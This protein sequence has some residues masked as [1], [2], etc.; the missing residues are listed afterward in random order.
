[1]KSFLLRTLGLTF[2]CGALIGSLEGWGV[3]SL[4]GLNF[5]DPAAEIFAVQWRY[6][7]L[8]LA[9]LPVALPMAALLRLPRKTAI[10]L[11]AWSTLGLAWIIGN[12]WIQTV[13]LRGTPWNAPMS[14]SLLVL[15]SV[16]VFILHRF[17]CKWA[18][19]RPR[20]FATTLLLGVVLLPL[21]AQ[22]KF[23]RLLKPSEIPAN[24]AGLPDITIIV[25]DTLRA[26]HLG[27]YGY[28]RSDGEQTSPAIDQLAAQGVVFEN[29]WSQAPWTRPSM[30]SLHSGLFCSAHT[31]NDKFDILPE[32]VISLA[33]MAHNQGYRTSGF[34]ANANVSTTFGFDQ[35]FENLWTIGKP[36]TLSSF[37]GWGDIAFKLT[38]I[39][40]DGHFFDGSD[41][42][43]LVNRQAFQWLDSVAQDPR[44]KFTY[45][46]YIDPHTPYAPPEG[47]WYFDGQP[48]DISDLN[49]FLEGRGHFP[50]FPFK[51]FPDPGP[52]LIQKIVRNYD[53]EIRFVDTEISKL[54]DK[55]R[56]QGLLDQNDWLFITS[57]HGEEFYEHGNWGHGQSLFEDQVHVPLIVLGPL[58]LPGIRQP[59]EV[60]LLDLHATVKE[61]VQFSGE[62]PSP[63][64]SL[65]GLLDGQPSA[66]Q[67]RV[68][69][70]ER[71]I[72]T[73]KLAAVRQFNRK[74]IEAPDKE[75]RGTDEQAT[76]VINMWFDLN[77]NPSERTIFDWAA[78][79]NG[80]PINR[81]APTLDPPQD[82]IKLLKGMKSHKFLGAVQAQL[83]K[84][85]A[86]EISALRAAGYLDEQGNLR[87]G[88]G[89]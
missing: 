33:E 20:V 75:A 70:A 34:S 59:Q 88:G 81:D 12:W 49:N 21:A 31:V 52:E 42:A 57:D 86:N 60:N 78:M 7:L 80:G 27:A 53:A 25:V 83:G 76:D 89:H 44:P 46:H 47:G 73:R 39:L 35:G 43:R 63:S 5:R 77:R 45:V 36:R 74:L 66:D 26:D 55:L 50:E 72:G 71:L 56:R 84:M 65:L 2:L 87:M 69:Y 6:G 3:M 14:L 64:V 18:Q 8:A 29:C 79:V 28:R 19:P 40:F 22:L 62:R 1:M 11:A 58:A 15:T 4:I 41:D 13:I 67:Q 85:S 32:E 48:E 54:V 16:S 51:S 23:Q 24:A 68:L 37:T 10:D 9:C 30:A 38:N 17:L 61:L 82:L